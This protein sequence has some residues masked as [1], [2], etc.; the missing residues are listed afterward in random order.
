[1][2]LLQRFNVAV[3]R[4]CSLL[5][6]VGNPFLLENDQHW[7]ELINFTH[8]LGSYKGCPYMPRFGPESEWM[9]KVVEKLEKLSTD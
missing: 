8:I 6:V 3:T 1:L 4:A 7:R 2:L 9:E 5:I